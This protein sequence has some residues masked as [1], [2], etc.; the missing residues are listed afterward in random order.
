MQWQLRR[1]NNRETW[2]N[3]AHFNGS[4]KITK[5]LLLLRKICFMQ[6]K[7]LKILT[8]QHLPFKT[9]FRARTVESY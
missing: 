7:S 3:A 1:V 9:H 5:I 2:S 4:E 8:S 6:E